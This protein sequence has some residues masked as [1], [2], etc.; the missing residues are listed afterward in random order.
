MK[1][2]HKKQLRKTIGRNNKT[3]VVIPKERHV[4]NATRLVIRKGSTLNAPDLDAEG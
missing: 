3:T 4:Y 1:K 2:Y